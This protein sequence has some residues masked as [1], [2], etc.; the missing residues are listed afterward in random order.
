MQH[1]TTISIGPAN[2]CLDPAAGIMV[3]V[4][5]IPEAD[6]PFKLSEVDRGAGLPRGFHRS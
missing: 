4:S 5:P 3:V 1:S 2:R 6:G